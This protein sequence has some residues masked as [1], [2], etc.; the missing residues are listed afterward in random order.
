[1][2]TTTLEQQA[3]AT[4][5]FVAPQG[6]GKS[7][8]AQALRHRYGCARVVDEWGPGQPL[9]DGAIHLSHEAPEGVMPGARVVAGDEAMAALRDTLP[10]RVD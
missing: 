4:V 9:V 1:M 6:S 7:L 8:A 2:L 5:V 10:R 3:A